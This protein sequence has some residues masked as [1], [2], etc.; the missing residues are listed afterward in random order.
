MVDNLHYLAGAKLY[1]DDGGRR[2]PTWA[3]CAVLAGL[4]KAK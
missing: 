3:S 4:L 2:P 1:G